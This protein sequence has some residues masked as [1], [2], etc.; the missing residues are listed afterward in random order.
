MPTPRSSSPRPADGDTDA[1]PLLGGAAEQG[2][3][4]LREGKATMVSCIANL[5]S[6]PASPSP[7]SS[8]LEVSSADGSS[9]L[10]PPSCTRATMRKQTPSSAPAHSQCAPPLSPSL[11]TPRPPA[12]LGPAF[13]RSQGAR[14]LRRGP[15]PG[16]HHGHGL[17]GC[18]RV[19]PVPLDP[20][21]RHGAAPRRELLEPEHPHLSRPRAPV[22]PPSFLSASCARRP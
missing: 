13:F 16:H 19:R 9:S 8:L 10:P 17:R 18:R 5:A 15:D 12:D 2:K 20:E 6:A 14:L 1:T 7:S 4:Q 21:R 11:L 22:R 3:P